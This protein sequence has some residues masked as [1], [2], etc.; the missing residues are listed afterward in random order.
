MTRLTPHVRHGALIPR[1][2]QQAPILVGSPDWQH[3]LAGATIFHFSHPDGDFTARKEARRQGASYWKAYRASGGALV[4]AYLGKDERLSLARLEETAALLSRRAQA[5]TNTRMVPS[6]PV[7]RAHTPQDAIVAAKV[8][9]PRL[10]EQLVHRAR[11]DDA[12]NAVKPGQVSVVSAPM[13]YGKTTTLAQ[14]LAMQHVP[15]AW[16]TL[17]P[18]DNDPGRFFRVLAA[19]LESALPGTSKPLAAALSSPQPLDAKA[20]VAVMVEALDASRTPLILV[21]DDYHAITSQNIHDGLMYL[22]QHMPAAARVIIASRTKLPFSLARARA[23]GHVHELSADDLRFTPAEVTRFCA[24]TPGMSLVAE[25]AAR[26]AD[27]TEGWVAALQLAGLSMRQGI[28]AEALFEAFEEGGHAALV[29]YLLDEVVR[30]Q[31]PE[32]Q[33]FLLATSILDRFTAHLCERLIAEGPESI[34][35]AGG[36]GQRMLDQLE[37]SN[38]FLVRLDE[39]RQ[40]YRYHHLFS[41]V[42]RARLELEWPDRIAHLHLTAA[43]WLRSHGLPSEAIQHLLA[44]R[45]YPSAAQ[46]IAETGQSLLRSGETSTLHHWLDALPQDIVEGSFMLCL[47]RAWLMVRVG[48]VDHAEEWLGAAERATQADA[49]SSKSQQGETPEQ[50]SGEVAAVRAHIEAFR[51]NTLAIIH[52]ARWA[53]QALPRDALHLRSL[54]AFNLATALWLESDYQGATIALNQAQAWAAVVADS[55]VSLLSIGMLAQ[56][57]IVQGRRRAAVRTSRAAVRLAEQGDASLLAA[58][59]V[60]VGMGQSLYE[61][62]ELTGAALYCSRAADI[63]ERLHSADLLVYAYTVMAQVAQARGEDAVDL[64]E[65]AAAQARLAGPRSWIAAIMV[66]QQTRVAIQLGQLSALEHFT[67]PGVQDYVAAY[68]RLTSA[69]LL[70]S[71]G[72]HAAALGLLSEHLKQALGAGAM[73]MVIETRLLIALAYQ[74][75]GN[76]PAAYEAL[77]HAL[78]LAEPEGYVRLIVDE[79]A[80]IA[81]LLANLLARLHGSH[82]GEHGRVS[83]AYLR[84]LLG[85]GAP[86]TAWYAASGTSGPSASVT[87]EALS[88]REREILCLVADGYSN[89]E[90]AHELVVATNTIKWHMTNIYGKLGVHRRTSAALWARAHIT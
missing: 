54:S 27:A 85:A 64:L 76:L 62:N 24:Q 84:R 82:E 29:D 43:D 1:A 19:A 79:G 89:A 20:L 81:Q 63:G 21:L 50:R 32:V 16:V 23:H 6:L 80:P 60:Y 22:I 7:D 68:D 14:W 17:D 53:L 86:G 36:T 2:P 61:W 46:L 35:S 42:L 78:V 18:D 33:H 48:E 5:H 58:G 65:R 75:L 66:G 49:L 40:W 8:R 26:L 39:E 51:G 30:L 34:T 55:Y 37:H 15:A 90:I 87:P 52:H 10:G 47:L 73:G 41:Q 88:E 3:W 9:Y 74:S 57:E 77:E 38:L 83:E 71:H 25:Q 67:R 4:R 31:P 70:L 28:E 56:L 45:E 13:G 59:F 12:L 72:S 11:M 44:A 69:R